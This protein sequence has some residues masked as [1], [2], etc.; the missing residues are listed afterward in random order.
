MPFGTFFP[1]NAIPHAVLLCG[2]IW[3]LGQVPLFPF[4]PFG[5]FVL[6]L[7]GILK[8]SVLPTSSLP[9]FTGALNPLEDLPSGDS[10]H[11]N[12]IG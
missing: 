11:L 10:E 2:G 8:D 1:P 5:N 3:P 6:H 4:G 7:T 12:R 9:A